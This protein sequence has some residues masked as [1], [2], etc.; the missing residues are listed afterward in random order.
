MVNVFS[1]SLAV[2]PLAVPRI[3]VFPLGLTVLKEFEAVQQNTVGVQMILKVIVLLVVKVGITLA[4]AIAFTASSNQANLI[5]MCEISYI[6]LKIRS[7]LK[8]AI[9]TLS[10]TPLS[11]VVNEYKS[12]WI[13]TSLF[14]SVYEF[15]FYVN[16]IGLA[17]LTAIVGFYSTFSLPS[18]TIM[19]IPA[20]M[21]AIN[22]TLMI[23]VTFILTVASNV[24]IESM[25]LL[26][27]MRMRNKQPNRMRLV[28]MTIR[29]LPPLKI[30]IG[31]VNFI[32]R[33]TPFVS[34]SFMMEQS[35]SLIIMKA[36]FHRICMIEQIVGFVSEL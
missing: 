18:D 26:E 13:L 14:N 29:S 1:I 27:N 23:A 8:C 10:F 6:C 15:R 19:I 36:W 25:E 35:I 9:K 30:K 12:L 4:G 34:L 33:M 21:M 7:A 20:V 32:E 3:P 24:W 16:L 2:V 31:S 5:G 17:Q 22:W 28:K 11:Q